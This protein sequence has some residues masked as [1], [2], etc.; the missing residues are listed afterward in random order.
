MSGAIHNATPAAKA[1]AALFAALGDET[2]L[3][4]V[5]TLADGAPRSISQLTQGSKLTRQAITKHLKVLEDAGVLRSVRIG[6]QVQF[7]FNPEPIDAL[8]AY[9]D[10]V[11]RQW[12][13]ALGRLRSFVEE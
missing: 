12:D 8:K 6:R 10:L 1:P 3:T 13:D 7:A 11:S 9:L 2:R 4:L 5:A